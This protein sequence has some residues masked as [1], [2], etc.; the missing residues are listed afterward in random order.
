MIFSSMVAQHLPVARG[1]MWHAEQ[2]I[3][4]E[5]R[6]NRSARLTRIGSERRLGQSLALPA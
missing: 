4:R 6:E 5:E 1:W 2:H 3:Q